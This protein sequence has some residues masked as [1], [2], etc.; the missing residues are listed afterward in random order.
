M[1]VT[2]CCNL[3]GPP[4]GYIQAKVTWKE[5]S[6]LDVVPG[7]QE[8]TARGEKQRGDIRQR[9]MFDSFCSPANREGN[10]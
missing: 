8:L 2:D 7:S 10:Q 9:G 1:Y 4:C 3:R 5:G 6:A